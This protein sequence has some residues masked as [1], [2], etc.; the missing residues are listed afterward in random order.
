MTRL[1][2]CC[3][4][5]GLALPCAAATPVDFRFSKE[6]IRSKAD[7]ETLLALPLDSDVYAGTRSGFPDLRIFAENR[8][9]R[10]FVLEKATEPRTQTVRQVCPSKVEAVH[11][12]AEDLDVLVRLEN[13]SPSADGLSIITP[14][15]D[16]ER[17]V[18]VYG[19]DDGRDWK[20]LV[21]DRLVFDYSRYMDV[22]NRDVPL[23]KNNYRYLKV[24]IAG[25]NDAKESP[26]L[27]LSRKYS[28]G[29]ETER[30]E[31]TV[32]Q[33]RS[34]RMDRIELWRETTT[35]L[36]ENERHVPYPVVAGKVEERPKDQQTVIEV[37]SRREPLTELAIET[38]SRNFSRSA[39][40]QIPVTRGV[41]T[42]W[43]SIGQ[44]NLSLIDFRGYR[45]ERL[46]IFFPEHRADK[47]R[48]VIS[49]HDSPPLKITGVMARGVMYQ[50]L[51]LADASEKYCLNY[52][53]E[54]IAAPSYDAD[55]V[56]APLRMQGNHAAIAQ[57]GKEVINR[58]T[59]SEAPLNFQKL[60]NNPYLLGT[61]IV[62]LVALLAWALFHA[63]RRIDALP[64]E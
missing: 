19:S 1:L 47:Y 31:A 37:T 8:T 38:P 22:N 20:P 2:T 55:A 41:R 24:S 7:K 56:L 62:V 45:K 42:D 35:K 53:A 52:G 59:P 21:A 30:T 63:M 58:A 33:R 18:H 23:P 44:A 26:F 32:L 29:R 25:I 36:S 48:I 43:V 9:E 28:N 27:D 50:P 11:P 15:T 16:Y 3:L 34:F 10:P 12:H 54:K 51:F 57:L 40:V 17:R 5:I 14:L 60:I 46:S 6:I 4:L 49:N 13:D 61:V 39:I 64:K